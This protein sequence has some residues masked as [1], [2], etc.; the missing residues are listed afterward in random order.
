MLCKDEGNLLVME[1]ISNAPLST[2][3][4]RQSRFRSFEDSHRVHY[5]PHLINRLLS[6]E[7]NRNGDL[8]LT[9]GTRQACL[10]SF[11][12]INQVRYHLPDIN[13]AEF[14]KIE[15]DKIVGSK[16]GNVYIYNVTTGHKLMTLRDTASL[17]DSP[18]YSESL[19]WP[20]FAQNNKLVMLGDTVWDANS[21]AQIHKIRGLI[22]RVG[23]IFHP[24]NIHEIIASSGIW[25]IRTFRHMKTVHELNECKPIFSHSGDVIY[26]I[27]FDHFF[28]GAPIFDR[29]FQVLDGVDYKLMDNIDSE[30]YIHGLCVSKSDTLVAVGG[31]CNSWI[32]KGDARL[33]DK[34]KVR[35]YDVSRRMNEEE[36]DDGLYCKGEEE[37]ELQVNKPS[38]GSHSMDSDQLKLRILRWSK[39]VFLS[40]ID[41][42][43]TVENLLSSDPVLAGST[44]GV[45]E[46]LET[47]RE[48][49]I[50]LSRI[51]LCES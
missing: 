18:I 48:E 16:N 34:S 28:D 40:T 13:H 19:N 42:S 3:S 43:F 2:S 9:S 20:T 32:D 12:D 46:Y 41:H 22:D 50:T 1:N 24:K 38:D 14:S 36:Q 23:S 35:L 47:L 7:I 8:L 49:V 17:S 33:Y 51:Q 39:R 27:A 29:S 45:I 37:G 10:R 44:E 30:Q 25:D 21:G 4:S 11:D 26:A 6:M 5:Q 15:Q 31:D